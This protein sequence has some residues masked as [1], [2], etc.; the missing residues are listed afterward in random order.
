MAK[1]YDFED[2]AIKKN[3]LFGSAFYIGLGCGKNCIFFITNSKK[4]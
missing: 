3:S 4:L 1:I 2:L